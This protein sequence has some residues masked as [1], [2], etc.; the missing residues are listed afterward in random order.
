MIILVK[1]QNRKRLLIKT[2]SV[3]SLFI[4]F[5][6]YYNHM[7]QKFQE[8]N[9]HLSTKLDNKEK[10][11]KKLTSKSMKLEN[12]ITEE[13]KVLAELLQ[14]RNIISIKVVKDKLLIICNYSTDIEPLLVRYGAHALVKNSDTDIKIAIDLA[15]IVENRYEA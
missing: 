13:A 6:L 4:M 2:L 12:L 7:S 14:Q 1:N 3:V 5:F 15:I 10:E 9:F 11:E 8:E